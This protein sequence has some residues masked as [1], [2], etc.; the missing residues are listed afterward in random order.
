VSPHY[1]GDAVPRYYSDENDLRG[2]LG[3]RI[4]LNEVLEKANDGWYYNNGDAFGLKAALLR[5]CHT[6]EA[7]PHCYS[8]AALLQ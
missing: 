3:Q 7:M 1:C 4:V 2:P 6:I 8:D 5:R